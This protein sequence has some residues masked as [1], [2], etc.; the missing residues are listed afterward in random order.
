MAMCGFFG[1][2]DADKRVLAN[3]TTFAEVLGPWY[4][5]A[6]KAFGPSRCM[7]ESNSPVVNLL[8]I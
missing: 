6:I 3:P 8:F 7:F 4:R 5:F 2:A 1:K